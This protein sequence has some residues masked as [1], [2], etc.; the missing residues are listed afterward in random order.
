[1]VMLPMAT[2]ALE[3]DRGISIDK[4]KGSNTTCGVYGALPK[5]DGCDCPT[6]NAT[7]MSSDEQKYKCSK[8]GM[9]LFRSKSQHRKRS[10]NFPDF[11]VSNF[12]K[13]ILEISR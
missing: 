8:I 6:D 5:S 4:I 7:F 10:T 2:K 1:M 12:Y 9:F 11:V 3:I 13:T